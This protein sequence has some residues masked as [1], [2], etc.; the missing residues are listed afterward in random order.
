MENN[1]WSESMVQL[2]QAYH[3]VSRLGYLNES[4]EKAHASAKKIMKKDYDAAWVDKIYD[5]KSYGLACDLLGQKMEI[6]R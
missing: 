6:K 5:L 4:R 1:Y 2:Y 3:E